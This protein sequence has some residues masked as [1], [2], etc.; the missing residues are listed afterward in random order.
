MKHHKTD[1]LLDFA[2]LTGSCVMALG[3]HAAGLFTP[4]DPFANLLSEIGE[5]SGDRIGAYHFG[6][7]M[8][9]KYNPIL[10]TL[11]TLVVVRLVPLPLQS[12]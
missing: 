4:N 9:N 2:T 12:F 3:Y 10:Q 5:A 7:F 6:T 8:R 1:Y 11:R